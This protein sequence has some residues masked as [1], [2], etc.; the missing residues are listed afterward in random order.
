MAKLRERTKAMFVRDMQ[1]RL[2]LTLRLYNLSKMYP[3]KR[4]KVAKVLSTKTPFQ[5]DSQVD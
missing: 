5:L 1:S 3:W 4:E 2:A